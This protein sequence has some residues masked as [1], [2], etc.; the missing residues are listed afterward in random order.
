M[1][2]VPA[3]SPARSLP[4][5]GGLSPTFVGLELRRMFRNRRMFAAGAVWRFRRDTARV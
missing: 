2:A 5:M 4:A 1:T 3:T